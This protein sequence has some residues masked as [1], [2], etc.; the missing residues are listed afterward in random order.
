MSRR[1]SGYSFGRA[2]AASAPAFNR[3]VKHASELAQQ[4]GYRYSSDRVM[5]SAY[6]ALRNFGAVGGWPLVFRE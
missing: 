3:E 6:P 4:F 5:I 1:D 2:L